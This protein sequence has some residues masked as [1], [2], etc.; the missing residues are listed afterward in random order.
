MNSPTGEVIHPDALTCAGNPGKPVA[1]DG[2]FLPIFA[3]GSIGFDL[4]SDWWPWRRRTGF[5]GIDVG[6][7]VFS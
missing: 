7:G 4:P 3:N 2:K 1:V 6:L 5:R